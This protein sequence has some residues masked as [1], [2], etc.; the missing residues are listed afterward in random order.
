MRALFTINAAGVVS[1]LAAPNF[2]SGPGPFC[3]HGD[4]DGCGEPARHAERHGERDE[5]Q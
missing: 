1:F 5:R 4:G 2:E 3:D